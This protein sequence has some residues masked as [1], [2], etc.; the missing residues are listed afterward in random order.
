MNR[1]NNVAKILRDLVCTYLLTESPVTLRHTPTRFTPSLFRTIDKDLHDEEGHVSIKIRRDNSIFFSGS[2]VENILGKLGV[3]ELPGENRSTSRVRSDSNS[4]HHHSSDDT[5][6]IKELIVLDHL[7]F[8]I[9]HDRF[10][11]KF[12]LSDEWKLYFKLKAMLDAGRPQENDFD[13]IRV[14]GRGGFGLVYACKSCTTGKVYAMK[15]IDKRRIKLRKAEVNYLQITF[16]PS[17]CFN[18]AIVVNV[19]SRA[20]SA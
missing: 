8:N 10:Y 14:L 5:L 16:F 12:T 2:T 13:K 9:V 7:V 17:T 15:M 1:A 6:N 20:R 18:H 19:Y 3:S 11:D 4:G